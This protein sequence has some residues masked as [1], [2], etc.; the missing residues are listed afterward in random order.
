MSVLIL[1]V[2]FLI[3]FA[4]TFVANSRKHHQR[5][6]VFVLNLFLGWTFVGWVAALV[7]ANT[8]TDND[9]IRITR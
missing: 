7:W 4:P 2:V 8:A 9:S 5:S 1:L 3:Y 6:A